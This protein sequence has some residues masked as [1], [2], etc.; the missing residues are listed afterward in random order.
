VRR[1]YAEL[2]FCAPGKGREALTWLKRSVRSDG[3]PARSNRSGSQV[4]ASG[5]FLESGSATELSAELVFQRSAST[6]R[7]ARSLC[8]GAARRSFC[9]A[10]CAEL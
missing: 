3:T 9:G 7:R 1:S 5:G 6:E 4:S 10:P 8:E 2:R